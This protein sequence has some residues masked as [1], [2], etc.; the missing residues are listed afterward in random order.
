ML[1]S[2]CFNLPDRKICCEM[3]LHTF[4]KAMSDS[5]PRLKAFFDV[6]IFVATKNL[7][8]KNNSWNFVPWLNKRYLKFTFNGENKSIHQSKISCYANHGSRQRIRSKSIRIGYN[9]WVLAETYGYV[10]QFEPNQGVKKR[11]QVASSTKWG[12]GENV[13]LQLMECLPPTVSYN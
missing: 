13:V 8:N 11:K 12:L 1:L 5:M 4:V 9:I 7:I 2:R 3:S 6:S 10:V